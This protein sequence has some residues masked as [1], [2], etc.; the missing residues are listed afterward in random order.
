MSLPILI[1]AEK[2][3]VARDLARVLG[4]PA[5]GA[6]GCFR[7]GGYVITWCIGHLVE[8]E[9]PAAYAPA[10]RRWSLQALPMLPEQFRLRP[11]KSTFRQWRIVR[12]LLR[13]REF[14]AVVNAC[15]AGREGELIF[16]YCYEL[17][18]SRLPIRRLWVSSLTDQAIREGMAALRPGREFDHLAAAARCRAAADWLVGMNAT[19]AVTLV[20]RATQDVLCSIGRVQ[21]PTLGLIVRREHQIQTFVPQDY[22]EVHAALKAPEG[23]FQA[24]WHSGKA[25]RLA[26]AALAEEVAGRSRAAADRGAGPV[27]ESIDEKVVREPPPL[28]FDLTSLQRTCNRRFGWPAQRTLKLAQELYERHK[29]ITYPRTDSRYLTRDLVPLLPRHF[30]AIGEAPEYQGFVAPLL[31]RPPA[32]PRRV[33]RESQADHHAIIPTTSALTAARLMALS[34]EERRLL[35]VV[36]RRFVGAFY[37]DAEFKQ[38]RVEVRVGADGPPGAGRPDEILKEVPAPPDRYEARGRVRLQAG[39]QEVAGFGEEGERRKGDGEGAEEP[40][41]AQALPQ[42]QVGQRLTGQFRCE[43]RQTRPPPRYSEATLLSAMEAA[44]Q[45]IEDEELRQQMKDV[46]LG[47]PATRAA[48]IET[49]IDRG[50][51]ERRGKQLIPTALGT[52]LILR[53]PVASLASAELT[54]RWEERLARIAR[55]EEPQGAFMDDILA[56]VRE[57]VAAVRAAPP[58]AAVELAP[59]QPVR[60]ATPRKSRAPRPKARTREREVTPPVGAKVEPEL[61]C[62]RCRTGHLIVGRRGWGCGRWREGCPLVV[63]FEVLGRRL[64]DA[65]LRALVCD[66]VSAPHLLRPPGA[67]RRVKGRLRLVPEG[68]PEGFVTME[69]VR[70]S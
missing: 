69:R 26:Q 35:D 18:G 11:I 28:L 67:A 16:R 27:V 55:G 41:E 58:P 68:S 38:T 17:A 9:E 47:T 59:R 63:P 70:A 40:D 23:D 66:G 53:L 56:Y 15:D 2:P 34:G 48:I 62:P 52:D 4:V 30:A 60:T 12:D 31:S 49:L 57:V 6:G 22:F 36:V 51:I 21:T 44:G 42:L 54:G 10:W 50:Y 64:H 8:L 37:P 45:H 39:W 46:G 61:R 20:R 29:L 3:A 7:G 65:D 13:S 43:A 1:L 5:K 24:I 33:F 19:R 14:A 25:R 32:P